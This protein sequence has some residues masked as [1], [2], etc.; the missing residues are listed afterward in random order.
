MYP[1]ICVIFF[2]PFIHYA[3]YTQAAI[4]HDAHKE[5]IKGFW[6]LLAHGAIVSLNHSLDVILYGKYFFRAIQ[7]YLVFNQNNV[8]NSLEKSIIFD[9][10]LQT[11]VTKFVFFLGAHIFCT[12]RNLSIVLNVLDVLSNIV[13]A[14]IF[15][16]FTFKYW[17][18]K[19]TS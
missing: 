1:F 9:G 10:K 3:S 13:W 12:F 18:K 16:A 4:Y 14:Q 15:R 7:V 17:L 11:F 6:F 8:L 5:I 19:E 2:N